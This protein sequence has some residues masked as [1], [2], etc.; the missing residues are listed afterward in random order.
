MI[1][2]LPIE[3]SRRYEAELKQRGIAAQLWDHFTKWLRYYWDF[4][5]KYAYAP[6][7]PQSFPP[8]AAKLLSEGI[9]GY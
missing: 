7:D 5:H 6:N 9:S 8:F 4:C 2:P 1:E 3:L